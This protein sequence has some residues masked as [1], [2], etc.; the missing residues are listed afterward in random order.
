MFFLG[1]DRDEHEAELI[2]SCGVMSYTDM[3]AGD[4]FDAVFEE[5]E[6]I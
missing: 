5:S 1:C 4:R 3:D 2:P 6:G